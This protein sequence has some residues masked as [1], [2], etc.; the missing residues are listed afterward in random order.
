[1]KLGVC[2]NSS[3]VAENCFKS[4]HVSSWALGTHIFPVNDTAQSCLFLV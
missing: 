1:M 2:G 4:S 3:L